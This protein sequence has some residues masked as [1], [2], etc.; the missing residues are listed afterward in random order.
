MKAHL[1]RHILATAV[2]LAAQ[3][4]NEV[5]RPWGRLYYNPENPQHHDANRARMI[6]TDQPD[7][8]IAQLTAFYRGHG[9]EPRALLHSL[10]EPADLAER[11]RAHG[12]AVDSGPLSV[13]TWEGAAPPPPSLPTGVSIERATVADAPQIGLIRSEALGYQRGWITCAAARALVQR[14]QRI[15]A[16]PLFLLYTQENAGRIYQ[17]AG[18]VHAGDLVETECWSL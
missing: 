4:S 1:L 12:F 8:V 5:I 11:F 15:A 16:G 6:R 17:R 10:T 2:R 18:F 13:M 9:L 14:I 7:Q 3:F